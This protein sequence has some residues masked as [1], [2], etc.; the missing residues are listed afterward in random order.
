M[1]GWHVSLDHGDPG[2]ARYTGLLAAVVTGG[3]ALFGFFLAYG[4]SAPMR[5]VY[6]GGTAS[7]IMGTLIVPSV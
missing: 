6:R 1:R 2:N 4:S 5:I 3:K 7:W